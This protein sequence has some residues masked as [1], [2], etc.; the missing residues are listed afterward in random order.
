MKQVALGRKNWLFSGSVAGGERTTGFFTLVSSAL[1]NDLD[2]RRYVTD[3]LE[4]LLS[5][6]TDYAA[7]LPWNWAQVHPDAIRQYRI[8]ERSQRTQRKS[9]HRAKRRRGR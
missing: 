4:Q 2:V 5:G 3:V 1:R 6:V 7:L 9:Q 8:E